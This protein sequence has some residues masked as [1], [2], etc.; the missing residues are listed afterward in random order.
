MAKQAKKPIA[1]T[2]I[3][4]R[5]DLLDLPS[6]QHKAGLAGLL[7]QIEDMRERQRVGQLRADVEIPE[8]IEQTSTTAVIR[9]TKR[10]TQDLFDDLYD[11]EML[12][13]R[14]KSKSQRSAKKHQDA[15]SDPKPAEPKSRF[16]PAG[17]FLRNFTEGDKEAWRK[18]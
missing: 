17:H 14:S 2:S 6:A 3:D 9:F 15:N 4:V 12:E 11:A 1:P 7:L 18:L 8:V 16:I 13:T 5:Y 10:S